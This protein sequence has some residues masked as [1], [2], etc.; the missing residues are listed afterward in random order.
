MSAADAQLKSTADQSVHLWAL[1]CLLRAAEAS[2]AQLSRLRGGGG[3]GGGG[4]GDG[5]EVS[6]GAAGGTAAAAAAA[7]EAL[8]AAWRPVW[9]TLL[10]AD[11][12]FSNPTGRCER[13]GV[14]EAVVAV[15]GACMRERL[16]EPGFVTKEQVGG[17][18]GSGSGCISGCWRR[19]DRSERGEVLVLR[20][21]GTMLPGL[22]FS[23]VVV[24]V[25]VAVVV[26]VVV[27]V[28][29]IGLRRL[30]CSK[31]TS[32]KTITAAA[33]NVGPRLARAIALPFQDRLWALPLFRAPT[34][35][36]FSAEPFRLVTAF[37][38][39]ADLLE[40]R[41]SICAQ[42]QVRTG[43]PPEVSQEQQLPRC[44]FPYSCVKVSSLAE[45]AAVMA[46]PT[47]GGVG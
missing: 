25:V 31:P 27:V 6:G 13:G 8:C 3:V 30:Q 18:A 17:G 33:A 5:P 15:L 7:A 20:R 22:I 46:I 26:V 28:G 38:R 32:S 16:M 43:G 36:S 40:G 12:R 42:M 35:A 47:Y 10:R 39:Q 21:E 11:L 23:S 29:V 1:V 24:V 14:G 41:D 4:G 19:D 44:A 37:L 2:G 45:Y 34:G 9:A